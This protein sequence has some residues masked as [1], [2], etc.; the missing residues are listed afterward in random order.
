M[1]FYRLKGWLEE[2]LKY[3]LPGITA[4]NKMSSLVRLREWMKLKVPAGARQGG[5]L[6]LL[7]PGKDDICFA[8]MQRP[9][10]K[11]VHG[12]QISLP[13]GKREP[14]DADIIQT[15]LRESYE[16]L[17]IIPETV[18]ISGMLTPLYIPPSNFHITPVVGFSEREPRFIPAPEEVDS[19]I[20]VPLNQLMDPAN[21]RPKRVKTGFGISLD[22]PAFFI[23]GHIIWGATAMILSELKAILTE[24]DKEATIRTDS[25]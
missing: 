5:V 24:M 15:A 1:E 17:G 25:L 19:V 16:E 20:V 8:L 11:G 21:I 4:Q 23:N 10:Y 6:I 13:G 9:D 22:V 3:P 7:F 2:R 12:G 14:S 18:N